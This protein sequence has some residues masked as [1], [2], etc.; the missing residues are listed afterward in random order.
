MRRQIIHSLVVCSV[1]AI[2]AVALTWPLA[3]RLGSAGR[4]DGGDARFSIWNI[5][6]VAHA[7]TTDPSTLF[8]ANIFHPH[9]N[10]LAYSEA[11]LVAGV[12]A[13]PAWLATRNP[14]ATGNWA[15]L[16]AFTLTG[17]FTYCLILRLTGN[18]IGAA[19]GAIVFTYCPYAFSHLAHIQLLMTFGLPLVLLALHA[20]VESPRT[21]RAL[22]LGVALA[23]QALACGYYGLFAGLIVALGIIW[24]GAFDGL[25]RSRGYW[26]RATLA[27]V[28]AAVLVLPAFIPY[29]AI[30]EGGFE[31]S[32]DDARLFSANWRSYLASPLLVNRWML[33][34]IETWKEVLFPGFLALA[35]SA[36][37]VRRAMTSPH[38]LP[39]AP[40]IVGFYVLLAVLALWASFGPD[41]GLYRV[42]YE[43]PFFTMLRAPARFGV[44][45]VLSAAILSGVAVASLLRGPLTPRRRWLAAA[46]IILAVVRST[47]GPLQLHDM[48][49]LPRAYQR[50]AS[51]PAEP[52]VMFP[53]FASAP[54]R[55]RHTW[56][57]MLSAFSWRPILNGVSDYMPDEAWRDMPTLRTFPST[58]AW[59]VLRQRG[60][61]FVVVHWDDYPDDERELVAARIR[62]DRLYLRTIVMDSV[63]LYEIVAWPDETN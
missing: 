32:L 31:R 23:V 51:L 37:A 57:M 39:V 61:R 36:V 59:Q 20:F 9:K 43:L 26:L 1:A 12:L 44:L 19:I 22:W 21:S 25:W 45:V 6:W 18:R 28:T 17:I 8:D 14:I 63:S 16:C 62:A 10:A 42:L 56:Y 54:N 5:A 33:P 48:P 34:L 15:I 46:L 35:L 47:V 4:I 11:N 50:L 30:R 2:L 27:L 40:R 55:H 3:A 29:F 49:P 38:R 60:A 7:L 24:F 53:Y 52:V 58:A 13:I 41:A